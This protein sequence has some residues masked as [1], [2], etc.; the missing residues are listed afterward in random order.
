MDLAQ[1]VRHELE[2]LRMSLAQISEQLL[3]G[4]GFCSEP[5]FKLP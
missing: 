1:E 5:L 2:Q 3:L 4:L